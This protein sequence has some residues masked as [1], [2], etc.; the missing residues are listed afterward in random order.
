MWIVGYFL[1][2]FYKTHRELNQ[3]LSFKPNSLRKLITFSTSILETLL[4]LVGPLRRRQN[5]AMQ[6]KG[7]S[8]DSGPRRPR[9][10]RLGKYYNTSTNL[11]KNC[12]Y[13]KGILLYFTSDK[14][15]LHPRM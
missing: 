13:C 8:A 14:K 7:E 3:L 1:R 5:T 9:T 4:P 2:R 12:K 6:R 10:T 11:Y 15:V